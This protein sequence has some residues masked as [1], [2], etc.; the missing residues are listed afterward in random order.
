VEGFVALRMASIDFSLLGGKW[1]DVVGLSRD[2]GAGISE[3]CD[4]NLT[5]IALPPRFQ[6][7]ARF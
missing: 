2:G 7:G 5:T 4:A 3:R 1:S 6:D